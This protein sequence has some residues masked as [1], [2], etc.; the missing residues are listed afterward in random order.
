[1]RAPVAKRF[2]G[3]HER[4]NLGR[5]ATYRAAT[6]EVTAQEGPTVC[7]LLMA[8]PVTID[9]P[10][11]SAAE[12]LEFAKAIEDMALAAERMLPTANDAPAAQVAS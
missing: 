1:M 6:Y 4:L 11:M 9:L 3:V 2:V 5:A 12:A 10:Q 7:L 8:G